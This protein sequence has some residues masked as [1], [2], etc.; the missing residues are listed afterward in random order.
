VTSTTIGPGT[1]VRLS[2]TGS[3]LTL[4]SPFGTITGPD[5][6]GGW[7]VLLDEPATSWND[8]LAE[9]RE[10]ADHMTVVS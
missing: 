1:R 4:H 5:R 7:I 3:G 8:E 10:F 2:T 6:W 9:I